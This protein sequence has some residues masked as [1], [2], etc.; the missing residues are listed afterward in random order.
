MT[1]RGDFLWREAA[2]EFKLQQMQERLGKE[3]SFT[4]CGF[5]MF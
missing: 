4:S 3:W 1:Q 2:M 5:S